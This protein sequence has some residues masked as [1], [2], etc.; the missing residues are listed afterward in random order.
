MLGLVGAGGIGRELRS[1]IEFLARPVV[2]V[3]LLAILAV[4]EVLA[5]YLRRRVI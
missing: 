4:G 1:A 3:I 5:G 2:A